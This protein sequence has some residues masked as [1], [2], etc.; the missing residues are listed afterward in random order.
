MAVK[1]AKLL[2]RKKRAVEHQVRKDNPEVPIFTVCE[3]LGATVVGVCIGG[4]PHLTD[5]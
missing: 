4:S 5:T 3:S 2:A 1:R